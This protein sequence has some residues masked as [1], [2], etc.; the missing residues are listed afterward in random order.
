[1]RRGAFTWLGTHLRGCRDHLGHRGRIGRVT[2]ACILVA[3]GMGERLGAGRPK[4][5]V[6][7]GGKA[8]VRHAAEAVATSEV[9][10]HLVVAAP[11]S[12]EGQVGRLCELPAFD[13]RDQLV[14]VSGGLTRQQSVEG[15]LT[16]TPAEADVVLVHDAA[17]CFAPP[18]LIAQV[19][20][21]VRAGA[22]AVVPAVPVVDT[23]VE[24]DETGDTVVGSRD[25]SR[26]RAVQTPQGFRRRVLEAAHVA[27]TERGD[28]DATDDAGLVRRLGIKV[29][30]IRG[31]DE[32]LKITT[33]QD[34]ERAEALF[35]AGRLG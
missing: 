14:V 12:I 24:V 34:L 2:V 31:A 4:A 10:A 23:L 32:A 19:V 11:M 30:V 29:H 20:A 9:V 35:A 33:P 17:R 16:A 27:A 28:Q 13:G 7:V 3:A 15:A 21:A 6:E 1:M 5:L 22:D 25:R 18:E 8:L 26:L